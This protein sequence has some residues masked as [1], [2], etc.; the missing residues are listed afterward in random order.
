MRVVLAKGDAHQRDEFVD[1]ACTVL[2][3]VAG[4]ER[5]ADTEDER[6]H[7]VKTRDV[8]ER[9]ERGGERTTREVTAL[10]LGACRAIEHGA[11]RLGD[12]R[13]PSITIFADDDARLGLLL[14]F[15]APRLEYK[16]FV[17]G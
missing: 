13:L 12:T 2:I 1:G 9:S 16:R 14:N 6:G 15:G 5:C 11:R 7:R 10:R 8:V 4:A 3:A 17:Q